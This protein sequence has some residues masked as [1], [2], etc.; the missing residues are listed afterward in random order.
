MN[1]YSIFIASSGELQNERDHCLKTIVE[2][3]T[4]F[5]YLHLIPSL[6]ELDTSSG[7]NPGHDRIQDPINSLLDKSDVVVV[8]FYSK[9]GE[10][11]FEELNRAIDARKKVFVYFKDGFQPHSIIDNDN[12]R[13]VLELR[14]D[15]EKK[16][17]IRYN[18]FI[19]LNDLHGIFYP[20]LSKFIASEGLKEPI[21]EEDELAK[22]K[23][24]LFPRSKQYFTGRDKEI[25][26]FKE[27]LDSK[28]VFIAV[29]GPG[30]IGKTQFVSRCIELFINPEK[31]L[32][33]DCNPASQFDTLISEAGYPDLLLGKEKTDRDKFSAFKDKLE[34]NDYYLFLDNFHETNNNP[35]FKDFLVFIQMYLKR[36]CVIVIDRDDIRSIH[37]T[38]RRIHIQGLKEKRLEYARALIQ[39]SYN[40]DVIIEDD[41]LIILCEQLQGY[42]LAIDFAIYL[43]SKG[44][45]PSNIYE[46][47]ADADEVEQISER[48]LNE[49]FSRADATV[50]E[51]EFITQ[52]S[53][54]NGS[55]DEE[56]LRFVIPHNLHISIRHLQQ[57]NL[58]TVTNKVYEIHPLVKEF[59]YK[60]LP[61]K[62]SMHVKAA[63]YYLTQ[64]QNLNGTIQEQIFYHLIQ[65]KQLEKIENEIITK[66]RQFI[67]AGQLNIIY[68]P[69]QL[70]VEQRK[71]GPMIN[72]LL[73]DIAQIKGEWQDAII[74]FQKASIENNTLKAEGMLKHGEI[75]Y[76]QGKFNL[77]LPYFEN[78][79]EYAINNSLTKEEARALNDIGLIDLAFDRNTQ[80]MEKIK[81][82]LDTQKIISDY[83]GLTNSLNNLAIICSRQKQYSLAFKYYQ[84]AIDLANETGNK[85]AIALHLSNVAGL[86]RIQGKLVE[87]ASNIKEALRINE[88]TGD[89]SGVATCL[90][91]LGALSFDNSH[92]DQALINFQES[93]AIRV[94]IG[95]KQG[96]I[97]T[98]SS[99][100]STYIAKG[101][102]I[103]ALAYLFNSLGIIREIGVGDESLVV[104]NINYIREKVGGDN[105]K[106]EA[107]KIYETLDSNIKKYFHFSDFLNETLVNKYERVGRNEL[108]P[109]NSG[110]KFKNC[111]GR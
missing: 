103:E 44:E 80:A 49:I 61:N 78:A 1:E 38:P 106:I 101:H 13:A 83:E 48:L 41:E 57:K 31:V 30:G 85:I 64:P 15:I 8:L 26:E 20:D 94:E 79:Y 42:P 6:Y 91:A 81:S 58:L 74:H 104:S 93:L 7:N 60:R 56:L 16:S 29:D 55:I 10:F 95:D 12:Y 96:I 65:S 54:F 110:K 50:E 53:V 90:N 69:L 92:Y 75:L 43:L 68:M 73:G 23:L 97:T 34:E 51:R 37:I 98:M 108:C 52:I 22:N 2:V 87:A 28:S 9:I 84:Q 59:C 11:T 70:L 27:A 88:E 3:N 47:I 25:V 100:A 33:Y 32:W 5:P 86:K 89:R 105:F 72:I 71:V 111:H 14:E 99:I 24:N 77:A 17:K 21:K 82:A 40:H 36:G 19:S 109:C 4:Q 62:D 35:V 102:H 45:T 67:L 18:T 66:G 63:A 76:R 107:N 39:H 46:K